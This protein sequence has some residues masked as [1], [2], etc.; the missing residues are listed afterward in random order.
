[1]SDGARAATSEELLERLARAN[2]QSQ[3][4]D[5]HIHTT[6]SDGSDTFA[7]VLVQAAKSDIELIAFTNHDT[8][9]GLDE[10][11]D[12][13]STYKVEVIGGIEI[14]A[15]DYLRERKVH[16]LGYGLTSKSPAIEA[17]CAQLL[18]RRNYNSQW[19]L[20]QLIQAGYAIDID[21]VQAYTKAGTALYKQHIMAAL[22]DEPYDSDAYQQLYHSLFKG[23][24][25]C[26]QDISYVDARDAVRAITKDN[27]VAVLAHPG[28]QGNYDLVEEL[29]SYG[30]RG[31]EKYHHDHGSNDWETC[32][33]L[34][35]RYN[36]I[37]TGGSD[38][39]GRFGR[40]KRLGFEIAE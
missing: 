25:I 17:F 30:L 21:L 6:M 35:E 23:S 36:L 18:K 15:W 32:D 33:H 31:I 10:A 7:E 14:S 26:V 34:A 3:R 2:L 20:D 37:C 28:Q 11:I 4:C 22:I 40:V 5:L 16:I 1:M 13:A 19:Q 38:Y 9:A 12:M 27:G 39:H 29:V 24:G 8:T